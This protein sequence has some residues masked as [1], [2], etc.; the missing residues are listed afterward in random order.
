MISWIGRVFLVFC[1]VVTLVQGNI[2]NGD[3]ETGDLSSWYYSGMI[4]TSSQSH[5]GNYACYFEDT[6]PA[7]LNQSVDFSGFDE[8]HIWIYADN[9]G[10]G[11]CI[12]QI[13]GNN[14]DTIAPS[15]PSIYEERII[16]ISL[17]NGLHILQFYGDD[18]QFFILDDIILGSTPT[19]T[20]TTTTPTQTPTTTPTASLYVQMIDKSIA[21]P[22]KIDAFSL[23]N[24]TYL[25]TADTSSE[26]GLYE[27]II[28]YISP[29]PIDYAR[30]PHA[31]LTNVSS[32]VS[33]NI[34]EIFI[35]C[36]IGGLF[37]FGRRR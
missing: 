4:E 8:L 6:G 21:G 32:F 18:G 36:F 22:Q 3:F 26:F 37:I 10:N 20:P 14:I 1:L 9:I 11:N 25:F 34:L 15:T 19:P 29:D 30:N 16:N 33:S 7:T 35:L 27:S 28:I 5:T 24:G 12:I 31:L 2:N 13:D 17:Y 23:T